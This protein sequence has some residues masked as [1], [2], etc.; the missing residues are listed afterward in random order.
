M[1]RLTCELCSVSFERRAAQHAGSIKR[2]RKGV[3]CSAACNSA[4]RTVTRTFTC[5]ACTKEVTRRVASHDQFK[6]CS[7]R[8]SNIGRVRNGTRRPQ[9]L[10]SCGK[11]LSPSATTCRRCRYAD[12]QNKTLAEVRAGC[13]TNLAYH[14]KIRGLARN[15]YTGPMSCLACGYYLHIEICH[16]V[17]VGDFPMETL[18]SVVNSSTNLVALD[19]RCHWEMDNGY[20]VHKD[21]Q[22]VAG[23]GLE[24]TTSGI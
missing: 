7:R 10:C 19:R 20:L 13:T 6:Y 4:A 17:P 8:C 24:P 12:V 3:F 23:V 16:V 5:V 15:M 14:A 1:I 11:V 2:G 22:M 9:N 21:G 18:V